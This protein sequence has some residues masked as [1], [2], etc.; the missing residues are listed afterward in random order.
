MSLYTSAQSA[1]N[2]GV[3]F[4]STLSISDCISSVSKSCFLSICDLR[5]I[6]N[7]LDFSTARTIATSLMH[8]KLDYCNSPF[9]NLPQ[10]QLG[11]LRLILN[12][13]T[14]NLNYLLPM[15]RNSATVHGLR[16]PF[17]LVPDKPRTNRYKNSFV[18]IVIVMIQCLCCHL[19]KERWP[20]TTSTFGLITDCVIIL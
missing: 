14:D 12:V 3:I 9:F 7:T 17:Y 2:L 6:R 8:S 10:S 18:V 13:L 20:I 16:N 19:H 5:R 4:D 15:S 1:R 11:R